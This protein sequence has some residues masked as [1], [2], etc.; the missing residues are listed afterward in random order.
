[1]AGLSLPHAYLFGHCLITPL[2]EEV[3][4]AEAMSCS[5]CISPV[6]GAGPGIE[7]AIMKDWLSER[8]VNYFP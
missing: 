8:M 4:G 7:Q 6:P 1:M 5:C 3:P 2:E